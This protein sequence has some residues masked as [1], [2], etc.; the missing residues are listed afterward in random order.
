MTYQNWKIRTSHMESVTFKRPPLR[1][2]CS[3]TML[4]LMRTQR[5]RPGRS[6][7]KDLMSKEPMEGLSSRPMKN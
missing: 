6:S 4:M 1:T 3:Q 2:A 5:M 7:L